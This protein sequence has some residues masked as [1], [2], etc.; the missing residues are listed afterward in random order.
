MI[1]NALED[2]IFGEEGV[3][4]GGKGGQTREKRGPNED[5]NFNW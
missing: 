5:N 3:V 2:K 4:Y 1:H